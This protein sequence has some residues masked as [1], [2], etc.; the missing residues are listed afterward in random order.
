MKQQPTSF[1]VSG[2]PVDRG[3][4]DPTVVRQLTQSASQ[5]KVEDNSKKTWNEM[6]DRVEDQ[7]ELSGE[8]FESLRQF[9]RT[10]K[11]ESR[12]L[13]KDLAA[14]KFR[15]QDLQEQLVPFNVFHTQLDKVQEAH[16]L[17]SAKAAVQAVASSSFGAIGLV[18]AYHAYSNLPKSGLKNL[19]AE[20]ESEPGKLSYAGNRVTQVHQEDLWKSMNSLLDE[21]VDSAKS[22][23]KVEVNAQYYE[24]TSQAILH[25]MTDNA[26]HGNKVR[27][28]VDPGRLTPFQGSTANIDDIPD[29]MRGLLQLMD[30]PGDIA[31]STYPVARQLG[32][33]RDL[34]HRKGLRVGE[35]FLLSG[36]NANGGSG[37]NVDAGYVIEGPAARRLVDTFARDVQHSKDATFDDLYGKDAVQ[38]FLDRDVRMG[39][40][41]LLSLADAL[42]GPSPPGTESPRPKTYAELNQHF[43]ERGFELHKFID[44]PQ[45][46]QGAKL[47]GEIEKNSPLPLSDYGKRRV[48]DLL[49]LVQR[50]INSP[51]NQ[52]KLNDISLPSD[53]PKGTTVVSLADTPTEREAL[54][55]QTIH[56]AE[57]HIYMPAFVIT[58]PVAAA[59]ATKK[60][61]MEASG[62]SIDI[63]ILADPGIYPD[64]GTPNTWGVKYLED[65]DIPVR[66]AVLPRTGTHDRKIHAKELLTDKADFVGSTN[67]SKKGLRENHEH[68]GVIHF[69]DDPESQA[70]Q[71]QGKAAFEDL[72]DNY[73][74]ATNSK[75][76]AERWKHGYQGEDR[77][78]QVE[79]ARGGAIRQV[80]RGISNYEKESAT[81]MQSQV[82]ER[83]LNKQVVEFVQDGAD[84]GNATLQA[85][86]DS[87]GKEEF[88]A[89]LHSLDSYKALRKFQS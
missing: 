24:L 8:D 60:K 13:R 31:V 42:D 27:I 49:K 39:R 30:A 5:L 56:E 44:L 70:L 64:G 36:M 65:N 3:R 25:K 23:K 76:T 46:E 41:G 21:G 9:S 20:M 50:E 48:I 77:E 7:D 57:K 22:G 19:V 47:D 38:G 18:T 32:T 53:D 34:M 67:F 4:V 15:D 71:Q 87:M 74:L 40:R 81:W 43:Q 68:S 55:I 17:G 78:F 14:S 62:K 88:L 54:L 61:E 51:E 2:A 52:Q 75:T 72:W 83:G 63:R 79:Q 82:E 89:G 80:I 26:A 73:S 35:K 59:I 66:W 58:R 37:E 6:A 33:H 16:R 85:V 29:K 10:T 11:S 1:V 12:Q 28:N 69:N 86:Q 45:E 84:L